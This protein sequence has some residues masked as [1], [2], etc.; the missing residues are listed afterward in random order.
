MH[1]T[2]VTPSIFFNGN[3]KEAI[4]VYERAL[5]AKIKDLLHYGDVPGSCAEADK[6]HVMHAMLLFG[7]AILM[8]SDSPSSHPVAEGS[9]VQVT[10]T[11]DDAE[12]MAS[13]F[14]A[15]ASGG[16]VGMPVTDTFW[17]AK[18]GSL[19]DAFGVCWMFICPPTTTE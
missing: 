4:G 15:L 16:T 18:L 14:D 2:H 9:N 7:D 8:I 3:A 19:K 13:R 1:V 12:D 6:G 17:G 5:G 11:F 10:L